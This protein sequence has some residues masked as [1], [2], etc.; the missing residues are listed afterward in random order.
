MLIS[1]A[2]SH[3]V[4][5]NSRTVGANAPLMELQDM[6]AKFLLAMSAALVIALPAQAGVVLTSVPGSNPYSGPTPTYDFETAVPASG[7]SIVTGNAAGQHAQPFGSTGKYWSVGPTDGSPGILDLTG[8]G[9]IQS[10][11]FIWGSVDA[12]NGLDVLANDLTM[13]LY[14]FTGIDA[15]VNPNGNQANPITNPLA[16]LTL[17]GADISLVGG[18]RLTSSQ[19]AFEIDNLSVAGVPEPASWAMML[20]GFGMIGGALRR[21][22]SAVAA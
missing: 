10:I 7:G 19:N 1:E 3:D 13:V 4:G 20:A 2:N 16:T 12:Y 6:K 21:R 17:S 8:F 15:A 14:S 22:S 9:S 11:S 18:L 5:R